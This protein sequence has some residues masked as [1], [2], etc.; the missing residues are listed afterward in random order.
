MNS[1]ELNRIIEKAQDVCAKSGGRLTEKRRGV[2]NSYWFPIDLYQPM[3]S[4]MLTVRQ[5]KNLCRL[6]LYIAF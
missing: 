3:K 1:A 6:C 5:R 4:P 2:L